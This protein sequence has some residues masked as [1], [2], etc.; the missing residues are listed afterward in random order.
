MV[1][2]ASHE[3]EGGM[4]GAGEDW[5]LKW[6]GMAWQYFQAMLQAR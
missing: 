1:H 2:I 6:C 5:D 3:E 4:G